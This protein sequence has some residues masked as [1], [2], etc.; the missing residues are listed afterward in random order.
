MTRDV[1]RVAP[2][3]RQRLSKL[4]RTPEE[5]VAAALLMAALLL[6]AAQP[7]LASGDGVRAA[8]GRTHLPEVGGL[9]PRP[10]AGP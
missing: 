8:P 3:L 6:V 1:T 7:M 5:K 9:V 4:L 10:G 2:G